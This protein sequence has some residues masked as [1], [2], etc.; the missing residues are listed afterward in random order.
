MAFGWDQTLRPPDFSWP[1]RSLGNSK[2]PRRDAPAGQGRDD[3][4]RSRKRVVGMPRVK[5]GAL[6]GG[7]LLR[8]SRSFPHVVH[9][10]LESS[11]HLSGGERLG[12]NAG[13]VNALRYRRSPV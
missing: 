9:E 8:A 2:T 5:A 13:I 6:N 3:E 11:A 1:L 7:S 4:E 10:L 12:L